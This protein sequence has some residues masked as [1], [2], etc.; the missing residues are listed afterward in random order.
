MENQIF[1]LFGSYYKSFAITQDELWLSKTRFKKL[2]KFEAEV[3]KKG[4]LKT[5]YSYPFSSI[6]NISF[7]E[8][9]ES[10]TIKHKNIKNEDKKLEIEFGDKKLSNRFGHFLG[11]KLKM[12]KIQNQESKWQSSMFNAFWLIFTVG[13][14]YFLTTLKDTIELVN[15][16]SGK[17]KAVALLFKLIIDKIGHIGVVIIGALISILITYKMYKRFKNPADKI[18]YQQKL[19]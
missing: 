14:T 11:H 6:S 5:A 9:N 8:A 1:K 4:V 16:T 17:S 10:V 15:S 12:T 2:D 19:F 18:L 7:N 13:F 3:R